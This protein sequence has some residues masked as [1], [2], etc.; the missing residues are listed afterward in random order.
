MRHRLVKY[1]PSRPSPNS[2]A[3]APDPS[4]YNFPLLLLLLTLLPSS[5]QS[6]L[7][8]PVT[9]ADR[10]VAFFEDPM[11]I[12]KQGRGEGNESAEEAMQND[13]SLVIH[14]PTLNVPE[15]FLLADDPPS[16]SESDDLM[17]ME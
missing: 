7:S 8:P 6:E 17:R 10:I 16:Q 2:S 15:K 9:L 1:N 11:Q 3:D 14:R 13:N 5:M 12:L 4:F